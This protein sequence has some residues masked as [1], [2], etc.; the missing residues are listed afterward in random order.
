MTALLPILRAASGEVV[1]SVADADLEHY[2]NMALL[3]VYG[4]LVVV[5][6][7]T[8]VVMVTGVNIYNMPLHFLYVQG[9]WSSSGRRLPDYAW[10]MY[11]GVGAGAQLVFRPPFFV[12]TTGQDPI[13]A[14]WQA[15]TVQPAAG[16]A[17][18]VYTATIATGVNDVIQIDPGWVIN[19]ALSAMHASL[20]GTA[21]DLSDYHKLE[22][23]ETREDQK[24][25]RRLRDELVPTIP[26]KY[27]PDPRARIVPGRAEWAR[28]SGK[29]VS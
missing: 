23:G 7:P 27:R 12:P 4:D 8:P 22:A 16:G 14:G 24:A 11:A 25:E 26:A 18:A 5:T 15:K 2:V 21:S 1:A 10:E 9:I 6:T 17:P 20:G 13:I 29:I 19:A 3:A 28:T